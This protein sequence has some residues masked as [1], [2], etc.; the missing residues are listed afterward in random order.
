MVDSVG[1]NGTVRY[2]SAVTDVAVSNDNLDWKR[3]EAY[4]GVRWFM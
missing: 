3:W 2:T 4:L 1:I